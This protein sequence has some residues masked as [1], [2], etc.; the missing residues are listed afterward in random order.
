MKKNLKITT[1]IVLNMCRTASHAS[2]V[3]VERAAGESAKKLKLP[4]S[5]DFNPYKP[6]SDLAISFAFNYKRSPQS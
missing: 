6:G 2:E 3:S 4:Y 5:D 1:E